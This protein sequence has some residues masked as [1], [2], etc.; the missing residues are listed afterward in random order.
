MKRFPRS[1]A[2]TAAAL[3]VVAGGLAA[4]SPPPPYIYAPELIDRSNP[5]FKKKRTDRN[6]FTICYAKWGTN[7]KA[8][9][10]LAVKE[11]GLYG[12]RPV[13][14][15][16][17]YQLCPLVAPAGAHYAC[18]GKGKTLSDVTQ[19]PE[20]SPLPQARPPQSR[21]SAASALGASDWAPATE[22]PQ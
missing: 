17:T 7:A 10:D 16:T 5:Y 20:P 19:S 11:C 9:R 6:E 21:P 4:C 1:L 12:K 3:A 18:V 13:F 14:M 2:L 15:D 8:V 22:A